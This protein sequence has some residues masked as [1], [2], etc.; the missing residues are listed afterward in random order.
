MARWAGQGVRMSEREQYHHG[1]LR[2]AIMTAA[3]DTLAEQGPEAL[4]MRALARRAG[5]SHAAPAHHFTDRAGLLTAVATEGYRLLADALAAEEGLL[6][7]GAGYVRFA[8]EHPGH[9]RVMFTPGLLHE[10]D[11]ELSAERGRLADVLRSSVAERGGEEHEQE[12]RRLAAW[13]L[14]HGFAALTLSGGLDAA[15][16]GRDPVEC[17]RAVAAG[18][19]P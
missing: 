16:G 15:L 18:V 3:V 2:R 17:F 14:A 7:H 13:S 9:F 4:S 5:V 8:R 12:G 10:D 19:F 1:D 6:A 11:A